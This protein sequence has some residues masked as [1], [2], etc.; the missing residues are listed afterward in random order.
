[1]LEIEKNDTRFSIEIHM[2]NTSEQMEQRVHTWLTKLYE[3]IQQ[4]I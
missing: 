1:M 3:E 2:S 4:D